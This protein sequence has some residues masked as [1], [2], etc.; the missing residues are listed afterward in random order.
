MA[1]WARLLSEC[2]GL[3]L[4]RGFESRPPRYMK[5]VQRWARFYFF[6][7]AGA[8]GLYHEVDGF[9]Q[10]FVFHP[11]KLDE[12]LTQSGHIPTLPWYHPEPLD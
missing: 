6:I 5:R 12:A 2:R 8:D 9:R 3:N 11:L 10:L 7:S 4:G 1:D